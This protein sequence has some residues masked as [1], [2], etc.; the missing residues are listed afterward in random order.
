MTL[1]TYKEVMDLITEIDVLSFNS[2]IDDISKLKDYLNQ[3]QEKK[4]RIKEL[5]SDE[6]SKTN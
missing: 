4:N 5:L 6:V 3:I 1:K 2:G